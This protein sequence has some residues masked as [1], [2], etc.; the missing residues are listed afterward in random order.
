MVAIKFKLCGIHDTLIDDLW[1][2]GDVLFVT[3]HRET[4][5]LYLGPR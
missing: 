1:F 3:L 5:M 2:L 4:T